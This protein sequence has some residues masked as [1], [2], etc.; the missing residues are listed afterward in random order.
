MKK[1]YRQAEKEL[2]KKWDEFIAKSDAKIDALTKDLSAAQMAGATSEAKAIEKKLIQAKKNFTFGNA[3]YNSMVDDITRS[4]AD[5]NKAA[6]DMLNGKMSGI[7]VT[8]YNHIAA[9][10]K[11][12][13]VSFNMVD[14]ATVTRLIRDGKIKLPPRKMNIPKDMAWNKKKLNSAVLQGILQGE[15]MDKIADRLIPVIGNNEKAAIR[16]ARTMVTGAENRGR[17]DSYH[18]LDE[19]GIVIHKV[20]IATGDDRTRDWHAEMDGQE[21][22]LDEMFIDGL[23]NELEYPGDPGAPGETVYNCRCA[24]R[25]QII[26]FRK[27]DGRI[28]KI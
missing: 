14:Q 21:V 6:V 19:R 24:M 15:S 12:A 4:L 3:R 2:R 8:N 5:T 10:A 27:A 22:E 20:W 18:D 23:G 11:Q 13:G 17:I 7:Y 1:E 26:G 16:N 28:E 9:A 25:S